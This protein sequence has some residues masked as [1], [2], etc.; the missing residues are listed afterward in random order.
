MTEKN[1]PLKICNTQVFPGERVTLAFPTPE[2]YTCIPMHIPIHVVHGKKAGPT[3]L[4]CAAL[5]GDEVN[6][7]AIIQDLLKHS[8]L[9]SICGTLL[10]IPV[11]NVLG[12]SMHSRNLPDNRDIEKCFPGTESGSYAGRLA[13]FLNKEIF[14]LATHIIDIHTGEP[15]YSK[16][17]QIETNVEDPELLQLAQAFNPPVICHTTSTEG[18]LSLNAHREK[19]VLLYK[20]G[21][22]LRLEPK[23]IRYGLQ[24]IIKIL[25]HLQMIKTS[26]KPTQPVSSLI[27]ETKTWVHAPGSGIA[28]ILKKPGAQVKKNERIAIVSDPFGTKQVFNVLSPIDGIITTRNTLPLLNEGDHLLEIGIPKPDHSTPQQQSPDLSQIKEWDNQNNT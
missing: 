3:V 22:A 15:H 26:P 23:Q 21:E 10:A 18:I 6:G 4:I 19:Q 13:Y 25:K 9:K 20:A 2:L 11:I 7:I 1:S 12:L 8:S 14:S 5:H 28:Q 24:G 17:P 16:L 27:L